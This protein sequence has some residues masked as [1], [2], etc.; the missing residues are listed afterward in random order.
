MSTRPTPG[1]WL[2]CFENRTTSTTSPRFSATPANRWDSSAKKPT[3][4]RTGKSP[5]HFTLG[6]QTRCGTP[7]DLGLTHAEDLETPLRDSHHASEQPRSRPTCR[8]RRY[9]YRLSPGVAF[10]ITLTRHDIDSNDY[11]RRPVAH[12]CS[13]Q[14]PASP[15]RDAGETKSTRRAPDERPPI[16]LAC[17][18]VRP[19]HAPHAIYAATAAVGRADAQGQGERSLRR[20]A[21]R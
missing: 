13:G 4:K 14:I 1:P 7:P 3:I 19:R 5:A 15:R 17:R 11:T 20:L 6:T 10:G 18:R 2:A 16:A 21:R 8:R 9:R 12:A